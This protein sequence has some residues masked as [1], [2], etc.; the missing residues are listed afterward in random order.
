MLNF[1]HVWY[2]HSDEA[3]DFEEDLSFSALTLL[4][5]VLGSI[6]G[7]GFLLDEADLKGVF[8]ESI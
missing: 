1:R 4:L 8:H 6:L 7:I 5:S 2:F 3:C